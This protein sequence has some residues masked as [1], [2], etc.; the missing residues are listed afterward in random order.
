MDLPS[1]SSLRFDVSSNFWV[2]L[3]HPPTKCRTRSPPEV[4]QPHLETRKHL[5]RMKNEC[6]IWGVERRSFSFQGLY[7]PTIPFPHGFLKTFS[8]AKQKCIAGSFPSHPTGRKKRHSHSPIG[9][10]GLAYL[11][12]WMVDFI[13]VN[14]K[15]NRPVLRILWVCA[16]S[17]CRDLGIFRLGPFGTFASTAAHHAAATWPQGC[18]HGPRALDVSTLSPGS[19]LVWL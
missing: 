9:S 10:M 16:T 14:V 1:S 12:R 3:S 6:W 13:M 19:G 4:L 8:L 5:S 17:R 11:P 18:F 15:A 7:K 2:N